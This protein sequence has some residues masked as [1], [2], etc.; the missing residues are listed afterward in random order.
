MVTI[1]SD[2]DSNDW[3]VMKQ[4][5]D[6]IA[7]G[8]ASQFDAP[9]SVPVTAPRPLYLL[10]GEHSLIYVMAHYLPTYKEK[11]IVKNFICRR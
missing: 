2:C 7:P 5:W 6:R 4:V 9:Y 10:N 3:S 8:L 11:H 1:I